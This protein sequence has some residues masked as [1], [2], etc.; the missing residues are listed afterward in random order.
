[1]NKIKKLLSP[2]WA[3]AIATWIT[4]ILVVISIL[5]VWK[6]IRDLKT[7]VENQTY[8]SVYQT[9]FDIHRYFLEHPEYRPYFYDKK[10]PA[11]DLD[12]SERIKLDTLTEWVCD[13]FDDVYQQRDTMTPDT[14]SKWRQFMKDIYQRSP[15]LQAFIEKPGKRWYPEDFIDDIKKPG[16]EV[17]LPA[18]QH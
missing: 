11:P 8:Q 16:L 6:Q 17:P 2:E 5:L 1:M 12:E 3:I 14:F 15:I 4:T 7:S 10:T 13:F 9:E 18:K